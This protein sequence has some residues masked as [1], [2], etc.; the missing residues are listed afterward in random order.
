MFEVLLVSI[1][2]VVF[3]CVF[4]IFLNFLNQ[5]ELNF[6]RLDRNNRLF[7]S[8]SKFLDFVV[9]LLF[10]FITIIVRVHHETWRDEVNI[11][12]YVSDQ[13][14]VQI[15]RNL[16]F[17]GH[18]SLWYLLVYPFSKLG[19]SFVYETYLHSFIALFTLLLFYFKSPFNKWWKILFLLNVYFVYEYNAIARNYV[20]VPC[21]LFLIATIFEKRFEKPILYGVLLLLLSQI[22]IYATLIVLTLFI[23]DLVTYIKLKIVEKKIILIIVFFQLLGLLVCFL[24]L[25]GERYLDSSKPLNYQPTHWLLLFF[26]NL[27]KVSSSIFI[28]NTTP[29]ILFVLLLVIV[30]F[31]F[32]KLKEKSLFLKSLFLFFLFVFLLSVFFTVVPSVKFS[33]RHKGIVWSFFIFI[34]WILV[35]D[36]SF[37]TFIKTSFILK[38][39]SLLIIIYWI[40]LGLGSI[41]KDYYFEYSRS[42]KVAD[43]INSKC[44]SN[45]NLCVYGGP[46]SAYP[47]LSAI[48]PFLQRKIQYKFVNVGLRYI[49]YSKEFQEKVKSSKLQDYTSLLSS[50]KK[51]LFITLSKIQDS[52]LLTKV[53][54]VF[55]QDIETYHYRDD[56]GENYFVYESN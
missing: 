4:V 38:L 32:I 55:R 13:T 21:I 20:L 15:F 16:N 6:L 34:C 45:D 54:L 51:I 11:W 26:E 41:K 12:Y 1:L 7:K 27:T 3:F 18:L 43:F 53:N 17:E 19:F 35:K 31:I 9:I 29:N 10:L 50:N 22:H 28:V 23:F 49:K 44:D 25:S 36:H 46:V 39:V 52:L 24:S 40:F 48:Q 42:K 5:K 33:L 14:I 30:G 56:I 47:Y 2:S 8:E 37:Y